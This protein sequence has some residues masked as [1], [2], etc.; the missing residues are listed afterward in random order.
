M[1]S[2]HLVIF[3]TSGK[4]PVKIIFLTLIALSY[5]FFALN[6]NRLYTNSKNSIPDMLV[7]FFFGKGTSKY[8]KMSFYVLES[9]PIN[10]VMSMVLVLKFS[11]TANW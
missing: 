6:W 2:S 5:P 3:S 8:L 4:G 10:C 1:E 9:F 7:I 11:V